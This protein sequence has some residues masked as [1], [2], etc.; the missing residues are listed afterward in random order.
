MHGV[1]KWCVDKL[2]DSGYGGNGITLKSDQE[3][4]ICALRRAIAVMRK[5][6][7]TPIHEPVRCSKSNGR[8]ENAVKIYCGQLRT[9]KLF[10]ESK[11]RRQLKVEHAMYSWRICLYS[12][13]HEQV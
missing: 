6:D 8:M 10:F 5:G 13:S 11:M 1:V 3:E 12:R 2:E 4:S 7:T 9:L